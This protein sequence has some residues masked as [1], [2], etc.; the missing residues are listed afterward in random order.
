MKKI[1]KRVTA[2]CC[3]TIMAASMMAM[4][5]GAVDGYT[6]LPSPYSV[7]N[8]VPAGVI[9]SYGKVA[10]S[11]AG[12]YYKI[13]SYASTGINKSKG[14]A[15]VSTVIYYKKN[16]KDTKKYTVGNGGS[17]QTGA[18]ASKGYKVNKDLYLYVR[19][20]HSGFGITIRRMQTY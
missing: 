1:L 13:P 5:A 14:G 2:M 15:T 10:K 16:K 6:Y 12:K 18:S 4:S 3:A 7:K 8:T 19:N 20:T 9:T 11:T 17:G